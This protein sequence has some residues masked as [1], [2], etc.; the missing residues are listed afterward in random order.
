MER[1]PLL[2][3]QKDDIIKFW[4]ET[5]DEDVYNRRELFFDYCIKKECDIVLAIEHII[6]KI[7]GSVYILNCG[8]SGYLFDND[9]PIF[10]L[11]VKLDIDLFGLDEDEDPYKEFQDKVK[12]GDG[13]Y[14]NNNPY[15]SLSILSTKVVKEDID[16]LNEWKEE[17]KNAEEEFKRNSNNKFGFSINNQH[18]ARTTI[19]VLSIN[20]DIDKFNYKLMNKLLYPYIP[21]GTELIYKSI[22]ERHV[23]PKDAQ[24]LK[25]KNNNKA[26]IIRFADCF[27]I[28]ISEINQIFD[29]IVD[30]NNRPKE[31]VN[32]FFRF[33]KQINPNFTTK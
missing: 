26:N 24:P 30:S 1:I 9:D 32:D 4:R 5:H 6:S 28:S 22:V 29:I 12:N 3:K 13:H 15:S 18:K 21:N 2:N 8:I 31:Y 16:L 25:M 23:L 14:V 20:N 27:E 19:N 11:Q 7:E 17:I 10:G 33:L